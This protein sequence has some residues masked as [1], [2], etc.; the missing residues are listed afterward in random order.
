MIA[1][2]ITNLTDCIGELAGFCFQ[3]GKAMHRSVP[4]G[5]DHERWNCSACGYVRYENP[6]V[7][8]LV[9]VEA[10]GRLLV[11]RRA[12]EPYK[13]RWAVPGGFVEQDESVT[14]AA[15][16]ELEEETGIRVEEDDLIPLFI[17]SVVSTNQIYVTFRTHLQ[18]CANLNLGIEAS[19]G[20]WYAREDFPRDEFWLPALLPAVDDFFDCL[21]TGHFKLYVSD[22]SETSMHNRAF[23]FNV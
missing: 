16:R 1:A 3:C 19:D 11:I 9:A 15:V 2:R 10:E 7:V 21:A 4:P 8:V 13:A 12:L 22:W 17:A 23:D 20:A 14:L 6:T 5:D 18:T